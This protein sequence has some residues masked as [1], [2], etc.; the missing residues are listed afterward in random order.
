MPARNPAKGGTERR[1]SAVGVNPRRE[2]SEA[3]DDAAGRSG[4]EL[5]SAAPRRGGGRWRCE[6][7]ANGRARDTMRAM[8][9]LARRPAAA[10]E[11]GRTSES[12]REVLW[13]LLLWF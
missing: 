12:N 6:R 3:V 11:R 8:V 9:A 4:A 1:G 5:S 13:F 2:S 7:E 10:A